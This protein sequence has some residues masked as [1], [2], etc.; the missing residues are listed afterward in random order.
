M[1]NE[2]GLVKRCLATVERRVEAGGQAADITFK[3]DTCSA[4]QRSTLQGTPA[5]IDAQTDGM[6]RDIVFKDCWRIS[7]DIKDPESIPSEFL[8]QI[9]EL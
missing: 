7:L 1:D 4:S 3:C 5:Q 2:Q 9:T 6:V 8:P